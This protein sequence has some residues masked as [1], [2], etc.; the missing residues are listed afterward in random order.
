METTTLQQKRRRKAL[1]V[2]PLPVICFATILFHVFGGGTADAA[3]DK[4][5][6]TGLNKKLPDAR[7]KKDQPSGK[8]AYYNQA[9]VDSAKERQLRLTDP[10]GRFK[11]DS[12]QSINQPGSLSFSPRQ[13]DFA[14]G[15]S[16]QANAQKIGER[17]NTLQQIINK[18]DKPVSVDRSLQQPA[19]TEVPKITYARTED[20]EL[21]QMNGLLEKILDIQ[22][23]ERMQEKAIASTPVIADQ[24]KAIPAVIE[25]TQKIVQ[26]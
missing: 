14:A 4:S 7:L 1:I 23:P 15:N 9:A 26:G 2:L 25:G 5:A 24:F 17:L 6:E 16:P 11:P 21:K 20:P 19:N 10:Y 18:P 12:A 22:H 8:L 3:T 13:P